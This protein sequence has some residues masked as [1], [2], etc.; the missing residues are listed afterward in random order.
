[1]VEIMIFDNHLLPR[2]SS[3]AKSNIYDLNFQELTGIL[4]SWGE[5]AYRA[6]Q[7]WEGL[8]QHLWY[9]PDKFTSL[10]ISLRQKLSDQFANFGTNNEGDTLFSNLSPIAVLKSADGRQ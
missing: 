3:E 7:I 6:A 10:S 2:S 1:V 8:Y 5:P 9:T 4:A